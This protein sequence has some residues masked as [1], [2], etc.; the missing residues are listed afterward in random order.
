MNGELAQANGEIVD[1]SHAI[2]ELNGQLKYP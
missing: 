2:Q 1:A